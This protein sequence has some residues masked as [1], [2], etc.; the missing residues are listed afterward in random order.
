MNPQLLFEI[1]PLAP[2]KKETTLR[3]YED[4]K[5][6]YLKLYNIKKNGVRVYSVEY[7]LSEVARKFYRSERTI[8]NIVFNRV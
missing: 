4:V 1:E 6:E 8:E 3:F 5:K 7:I 2:Q